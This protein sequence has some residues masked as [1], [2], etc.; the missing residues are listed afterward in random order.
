M[1]TKYT[2]GPWETRERS[3]GGDV[4]EIDIF[5]ADLRVGSA[6][7]RSDRPWRANAQLIAAAPDLLEALEAL[8]KAGN[9]FCEWHPKFLPAIEKARA[10][11]A[12]ARG[13]F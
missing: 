11:L 5:H 3:V 12:K 8:Q 10:A 7:I 1:E 9:N 2:R 6:T 13:E 4:V